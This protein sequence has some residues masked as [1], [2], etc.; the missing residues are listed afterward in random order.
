MTVGRRTVVS[1]ESRQDSQN[2]NAA[3]PAIFLRSNTATFKL[4][5]DPDPIV[6][7]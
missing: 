6:Q 7:R 1:K 5:K 3:D 2:G 4:Y